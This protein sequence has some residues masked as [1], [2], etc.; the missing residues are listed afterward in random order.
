MDG[1]FKELQAKV[2]ALCQGRQNFEQTRS[3]HDFPM[4]LWQ[5]LGQE[6]LMGIL[7]PAEYGGLGHGLDALACVTE[8]LAVCGA[9]MGFALA[10]VIHHLVCHHFIH[11]HG[12]R[13]LW[14]NYLPAMARGKFT[15]AVAVS[16][17]GVG[18]HPK[19]LKTRAV[20]DKEAFIIDGEKSFVTNAPLAD[21]FIVIAV[22]GVKEGRNLFS[23]LAVPR[24]TTGLTP[25]NPMDTKFLRP[26]PHSTLTLERCRVGSN[27][28]MGKPGLAY[29]TMVVPFRRLEQLL[30]PIIISG[31]TANQARHLAVSLK[32]DLGNEKISAINA[33]VCR[34]S[35][36]SHKN[37][38]A[39]IN[40]RSDGVFSPATQAFTETA[41]Q[42]QQSVRQLMEQTGTPQSLYQGEFDKDLS[43]LL[44]LFAGPGQV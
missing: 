6:S 27:Q 7:V 42:Y 8:H 11:I 40:S 29:E 24:T 32:I 31:A 36:L 15:A 16:E 22:T 30:V 17:P 4:D 33:M 44:G 39:H 41:R 1:E 28:I 13:H 10:F 9:P 21:L 20:K 37:V 25:G 2:T 18:A 5:D 3:T 43:V 14:D 19:H 23:A 34:L 12:S 38:K 26:C 35:Q